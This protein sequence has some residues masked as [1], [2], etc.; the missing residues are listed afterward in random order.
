MRYVRR[1]LP[2]LALFLA[3]M[4]PLFGQIENPDFDAGPL[5]RAPPGWFVPDSVAKTGWQA[6]SIEGSVEGARAVRLFRSS[7]GTGSFGNLMQSI[8]A[9]DLRGRRVRL[10]ARVGIERKNEVDTLQMWL[11]VDRA[12][13]AMGFFDNMNDRPVTGR[14]WQDVS[15]VA[16]IDDDAE[17]IALG[18]MVAGSGGSEG[19]VEDVRLSVIGAASEGNA[20]PGALDV[21]TL[22]RVVA[23][24][25][26]SGV[27][28]YFHPSDAA[29]VAEWLAFD[30]RGIDEALK[31]SSAEDLASRI[32]ALFAPIAPTVQVWAGGVNDAPDRIDLGPEDSPWLV[33]IEHVGLG[34]LSGEA[35]GNVY[36]SRRLEEAATERRELA[37]APCESVLSLGAGISARIPHVLR[38]DDEGTLPRGTDDAPPVRPDRP[39]TWRPTPNDRTVRLATVGAAWNVW[40]HFY[41]Y[42]DVVD[43]DWRAELVVALATAAT[44]KNRDGLEDVLTRLVAAADDGHGHLLASPGGSFFVPAQAEW[45]ERRL[46]VVEV[47]EG[48][49]GIAPGDAILAID[50]TPVEQIYEEIGGRI[51]A[52]TEGWR[53][54]SSIRG[55]LGWGTGSSVEAL[56]PDGRRETIE[57]ERIDARSWW[58]L[59][60]NKP[61]LA[62]EVAPGIRYVDLNGLA[63]SDL[64]PHLETLVAADGL[65]FDLRGYPG[66]AGKVLLHH[67]TDETIH[68]AFWRIPRSRYPEQVDVEYQESR[69]DVEP[70]EPRLPAN[71]A[72]ITDGRAI[73]YA[74]SCMA[75]V[76]AYQLG[77]IVGSTTAGTNGNIN[78]VMLPCGFA[79][80]WTGMRVVKHDGEIAHQ[81]VGVAPTIPCERT[82]AG[83]AAGRDELLEKAI[84]VVQR[85]TGGE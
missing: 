65:V 34:N 25:R 75:I 29:I 61:D 76:E 21:A 32:S 47:A 60:T 24:V 11:R 13:G 54:H 7:D 74:E 1:R 70:L 15:I 78:R 49:S 36:S 23:F 85:R 37:D 84:E 66:S 64:E 20:P 53:R 6:E 67:L 77:E 63:W 56:R 17:S 69:W 82:I 33:G 51:S 2:T 30:V 50:G 44:A 26:L 80:V 12:E 4:T 58:G 22:E 14:P 72:F 55:I 39:E 71:V 38:A 59:E 45:V 40:Q 46:V 3:G 57:I 79:M 83:V 18:F 28:R 43:V 41:P 10:D 62:E 16:D 5:G 9:R 19:F 8:A 35:D 27:V 68:S 31:A 73:S 42:W 52:S 81:G 48:T